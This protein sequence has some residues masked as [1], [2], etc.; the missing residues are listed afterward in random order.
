MPDNSSIL[1]QRLMSKVKV[2]DVTGCWIWTGYITEQGYGALWMLGKRWKAPRAFLHVIKGPIPPGLH[3]LHHCDVRA[4]VNPEHLYVGTNDD[5]VADM[6]RR[7]RHKNGP[8]MHG[9]S[10]PMAKLTN[11]SVMEIRQRYAA[12]CI[13]QE[14]LAAEFGVDQTTIS[15][16]VL[17]RTWKHI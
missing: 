13:R 16:V 2:D 5:N 15:D 9:E 17:R 14:D 8:P 6:M 7:G 10:D 4:C 1:L 3:V 11:S 12:G